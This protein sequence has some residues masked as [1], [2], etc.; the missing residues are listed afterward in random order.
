[1]LNNK[2][3]FIEVFNNHIQKT[4]ENEPCLLEIQKW[5]DTRT[6]RIRNIKVP[7]GRCLYWPLIT[8]ILR[9]LHQDSEPISNVVRDLNYIFSDDALNLATDIDAKSSNA[10]SIKLLGDRKH[11][12]MS[13]SSTDMEYTSFSFHPILKMKGFTNFLEDVYTAYLLI[14]TKYFMNMNAKKQF[15][16]LM[17]SYINL[18]SFWKN[19]DT[20]KNHSTV[21]NLKIHHVLGH[22]MLN[23]MTL[24]IHYTIFVL[25]F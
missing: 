3:E 14:F 24:V 15:E 25:S 11:Y 7:A 6:N 19:L 20:F 2:R 12:S 18:F 5:C 8:T 17:D 21:K 13:G 16:K 9:I 23:G 4:L 1:M 22:L 10:R